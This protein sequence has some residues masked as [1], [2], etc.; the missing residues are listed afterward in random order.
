M[1]EKITYEQ[2][3]D[4]F[5]ENELCTAKQPSTGTTKEST[6]IMEP[7]GDKHGNKNCTDSDYTSM[8]T[9]AVH[10]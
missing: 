7:K 6:P 1:S 10:G 8:I 9:W 3:M 4:E 5:D 2:S